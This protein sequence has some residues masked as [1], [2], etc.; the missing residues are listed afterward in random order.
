[1]KKTFDLKNLIIY[2]DKDVIGINK[3]SGLMVH[4][5]G[6]TDETTLCDLLLKEYTKIKN[7]GEPMEIG[8][9]KILRPG[10]VHRLDKETSGVMIIA[11]NQKSYEFLKKQFEDR[12]TEKIYYAFVYG[13]PKEMSGKV[14]A[15]IGRS[16][17]EIRK[18]SAGRGKRGTLREARTDY[19]VI[20]R[21][22]STGEERNKGSTEIGTYSFL[23]LMPKTGRTHQI[24]VHLKYI[25]HPIICDPL[26][27]SNKEE[28]LGFKRLAL[29]A[30]SLSFELPNGKKITVEAPFPKDFKNAKK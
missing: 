6:K 30:F 27:A 20:E 8:G 3:P 16:P 10:I 18:W 22:G 13:W 24:R 17:K 19:E 26:Y 4:G 2:E 1:M 21:I 25:N 15:P 28:A 14:D 9:K 23:K 29:H 7:V 11:K 5:D 12:K